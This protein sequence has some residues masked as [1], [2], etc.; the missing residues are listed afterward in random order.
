MMKDSTNR[1]NTVYIFELLN[2]TSEYISFSRLEVL[3]CIYKMD[4]FLPPSIWAV[5]MFWDGARQS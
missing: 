3:A 4:M 1:A 5:E 2:Y